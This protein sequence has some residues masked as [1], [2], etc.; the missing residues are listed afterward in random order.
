MLNC[1]TMNFLPLP[2]RLLEAHGT[3]SST[4]DPNLF[5]FSL[6]HISLVSQLSA[7]SYSHKE[8]GHNDEA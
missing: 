6:K 3:V 5:S 2:E 4:R 1:E 7:T 8:T